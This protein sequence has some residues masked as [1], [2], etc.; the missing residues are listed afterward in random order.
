MAALTQPP[1]HLAVFNA[2]QPELWTYEEYFT[3]MAGAAGRPLDIRYASRALLNQ[4]TNG[5]YRIP[6]PY[7]VAYDVSAARQILGVAHTPMRDWIAET[8]RWMTAH[9]A[10]ITP[11]WYHTRAEEVDW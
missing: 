11:D 4:W 10:G 1:N 9:Y 2:G 6:L 3:L 8:G 5:T 7:P